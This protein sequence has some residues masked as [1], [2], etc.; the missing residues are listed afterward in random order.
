[1]V[2]TGA[3]PRRKEEI[4]FYLPNPSPHRL[5]Q[6]SSG[7]QKYAEIGLRRPAE[8]RC[9]CPGPCWCHLGFFFFFLSMLSV[10][11]THVFVA[12]WPTVLVTSFPS[13]FQGVSLSRKTKQ[14][15]GQR[16]PGGTR[17]QC[18]LGSYWE[19]RLRAILGD[20]F[21]WTKPVPGGTLE[22][23]LNFGDIA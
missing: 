4:N 15:P 1:M 14:I 8:H 13:T 11:F 21:S 17:P 18:C 22:K 20:T 3:A 5:K 12:L 7:S 6:D 10:F 23:E 2:G 19:P 9:S 16:A